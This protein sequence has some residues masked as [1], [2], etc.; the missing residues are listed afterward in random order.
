MSHGADQP[1]PAGLFG[2]VELRHQV[3]QLAAVAQRA[4]DGVDEGGVDTLDLFDGRRE[5]GHFSVRR[6]SEA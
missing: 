6:K 4:N 2:G 3:G 5:L 1:R